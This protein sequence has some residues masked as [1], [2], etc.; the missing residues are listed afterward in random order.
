MSE[1]DP[2]RRA[3]SLTDLYTAV[4]EY[5]D[6]RI[7]WDRLPTMLGLAELIG[8]R[9]RLRE[10]NLHDTAGLPGAD[11]MLKVYRR[12][13]GRLQD[14]GATDILRTREL[15]VPR[16]NDFR[17]LLHL[18]PAASFDELTGNPS[19]AAEIRDAYAG[20]IE[21]VDVVIGMY[22]ERRPAG[23]VFSDTA[24]R[25]FIRMASRRLNS[26]R[27]LTEHYT[28]E[29]YARAGLDWIAGNTMATVLLR[30]HPALRAA[31]DGVDNAFTPWKRAGAR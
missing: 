10:R 4:T 2:V 28:P 7:G 9:T 5:V 17:R 19:W 18:D 29:V 3:L 13:D 30:H 14:L 6:R 15:G 21:K 11:G 23:F 20:D 12:P 24:F 31:L 8:L 16:Y 26:D 25:I 1:K 27:F 22:A